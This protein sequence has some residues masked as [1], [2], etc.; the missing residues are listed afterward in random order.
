MSIKL[1]SEIS[2]RNSDTETHKETLGLHV[3]NNAFE[4]FG[5]QNF[6]R[7]TTKSL[8]LFRYFVVYF[9]SKHYYLHL[10]SSGT[11]Y[12]NKYATIC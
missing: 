9:M 4:Q 11:S 7:E 10:F 8:A 2:V 12:F 5:I 6:S 1:G 3:Q